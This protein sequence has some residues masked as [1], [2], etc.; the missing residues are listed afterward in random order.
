[1][2][3]T[4]ATDSAALRSSI[5]LLLEGLE[6]VDLRIHT[7]C[8]LSPQD[9][10]KGAVLVA[11][12]WELEGPAL[13]EA[14]R[15]RSQGRV[16]GLLAIS[17]SEVRD[18][19]MEIPTLSL[20][21]GPSM[22]LEGVAQARIDGPSEA[23]RD[24]VPAEAEGRVYRIVVAEDSRLQRRTWAGALR[25]EGYE[26]IEAED[27]RLGLEAVR[28]ERPDLLLTDVEMPHMTGYEL[29]AAVKSDPEISAIPV[30]I[31]T[32][33]GGFEEI[34]RGFEAGA[35]DYLVK[36][37]EGERESFLDLLVD[38]VQS[39]FSGEGVVQ[40][41][42]VLVVDDSNLTR[43]LVQSAVEKAGFRVTPVTSGAEALQALERAVFDLMITDVEMPGM[44]GMELSHRVRNDPRTE[45]L[46]IL[47]LTASRDRSHR[48]MGRGIGVDGYLTKPFSHEK[49]VVA[50]ENALNS[51]R[52]KRQLS[53]LTKLLGRDVVEAAR[54]GTVEATRVRMTILFTDLVKFSNM[55][56]RKSAAE[57]VAL[58]N[59]YL[60]EMV[61]VILANRGYINKFIGDAI[62]ALF[63]D[64]PGE[65]PPE[66]RAL[67]CGL[68]MQRRMAPLN[69]RQPEALHMRMGINT[70][71]VILGTI[72]TGDRQDYT[73]I[74]DTVNR[75][76]R[77]EGK[78]PPDKLL[79]SE[80]TFE[81]ARAWV[82]SSGQRWQEHGALELKGISEPVRTFVL[83]PDDGVTR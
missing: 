57:V 75:A 72:G 40:R 11:G 45:D 28:R 29:C 34:R 79:C 16:A 60:D 47:V 80:D 74:G 24:V 82:E 55:C 76:A 23:A 12:A 8:L 13:E 81:K 62:M 21:C 78:C 43:S 41:G 48:E 63:R 10:D 69:A 71:E 66:V 18:T 54:K 38:R 77:L 19:D 65:D 32:T 15:W 5:T 59:A 42:N 2:K 7:G 20:P 73:V 27:G 49:L 67:R 70:G 51:R 53:D 61:P 36:P 9:G 31:L 3:V 4:L 44:N 1:M 50:L 64:L 83:D 46:P 52:A 68:E 22:L 56:A 58:L 39:I 37:K 26:I 30:V 14:L 35:S 33:L 6:G 17:L 25:S